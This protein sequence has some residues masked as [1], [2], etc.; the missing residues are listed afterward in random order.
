MP[1]AP[2]CNN[3]ICIGWYLDD[4]PMFS[5]ITF[6]QDAI[7]YLNIWKATI[8][9]FNYLKEDTCNINLCFSRHK[10]RIWIEFVLFGI[11]KNWNQFFFFQKI[12]SHKAILREEWKKSTFFFFKYKYV[13]FLCECQIQ[14]MMRVNGNLYK[15]K[16]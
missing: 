10:K 15:K 9:N 7:S 11:K 2:I 3:N 1:G 4:W 5:S 13:E 14:K 16:N 8:D 12:Y 6:Y